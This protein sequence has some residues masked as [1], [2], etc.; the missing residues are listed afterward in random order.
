MALKFTTSDGTKRHSKLREKA[1]IEHLLLPGGLMQVTGCSKAG[2]SFL[3]IEMALQLANGGSIFGQ[4]VKQSHRVAYYNGELTWEEFHTRLDELAR[5]RGLSPNDVLGIHRMEGDRWQEVVDCTAVLQDHDIGVLIIDPISA[6][7]S[8]KVKDENSNSDIYE[9]LNEIRETFSKMGITIIYAHHHTKSG[10]SGNAVNSGSGAGAFA[11]VG[12]AFVDM[13]ESVGGLHLRFKS[14]TYKQL[15]AI[16]V[17]PVDVIDEEGEPCAIAFDWEPIQTPRERIWNEVL[18][19]T[20]ENPW[21]KKTQIT[22]HVT[23]NKNTVSEVLDDMVSD[24]AL[25]KKQVQERGN[26]IVFS[27]PSAVAN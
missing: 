5:Y 17:K 15:D 7:Y 24:G 22:T 19:Y 21:S 3:L 6:T 9:H 13:E 4:A 23:G 26:P 18:S 10:A 25:V 20:K 11:R 14:R 1:I 2:K 16:S 12:T 27:H 8:G